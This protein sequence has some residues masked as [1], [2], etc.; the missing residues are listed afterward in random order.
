M[1]IRSDSDRIEI[2]LRFTRARFSIYLWK[3]RLERYDACTPHPTNPSLPKLIFEVLLL[4]LRAGVGCCGHVT[5]RNRFIIIILVHEH[6]LDYYSR[7]CTCTL[8]IVLAV[9]VG[10]PIPDLRY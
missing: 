7:T 4:P 5:T 6:N 8:L 2:N 1:S 10:I 9:H 3:V